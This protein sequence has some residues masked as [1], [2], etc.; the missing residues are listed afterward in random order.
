M[1]E[2]VTR[3]GRRPGRTGRRPSGVRTGACPGAAAAGGRPARPY[4]RSILGGIPTIVGGTN[5][6]PQADHPA[7]RQ[8]RAGPRHGGQRPGA[9]RAG[10]AR[11]PPRRR[12][13]RR[14]GPRPRPGALLARRSAPGGPPSWPSPS[15]R[16]TRPCTSSASCYLAYPGGAARRG[17]AHRPRRGHP[18]GRSATTPASTSCSSASPRPRPTPTRASPPAPSRSSRPRPSGSDLW[19]GDARTVARWTPKGGLVTAG[20]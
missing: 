18:A 8:G 10:R 12:G 1:G 7:P 20:A 9:H 11:R 19:P 5:A 6:E 17:A 15:S 2:T 16:P 3:Y 13:A 4:R 14:P